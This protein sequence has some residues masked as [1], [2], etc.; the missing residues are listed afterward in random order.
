MG[1]RQDSFFG[2]NKIVD[3]V[4]YLNLI[5]NWSVKTQQCKLDQNDALICRIKDISKTKV[6]KYYN[7]KTKYQ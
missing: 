3:Y 4:L 6:T 2:Y 1:H 7:L 5:I